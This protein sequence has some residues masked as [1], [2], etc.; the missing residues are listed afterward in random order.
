MRRTDAR[1]ISVTPD[2]QSAASLPFL[3]FTPDGVLIAAFSGHGNA[4]DYL[5]R[6]KSHGIDVKDWMIHDT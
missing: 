3:V 5:D 2:E 6:L 1:D 4:T